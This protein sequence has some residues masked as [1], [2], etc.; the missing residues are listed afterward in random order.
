MESPAPH[1]TPSEQAPDAQSKETDELT[2]EPVAEAGTAETIEGNVAVKQDPNQNEDGKFPGGV[3]VLRNNETRKT[4]VGCTNS[5]ERRIRQHRGELVGGA[6][7]TKCST[8]WRYHVQVTG[9][10]TRNKALSF[11]W[12]V[13]HHRFPKAAFEG[14]HWPPTRRRRK[15]IQL[16]MD[17]FGDEKF[18][19]LEMHFLDPECEEPDSS[20]APRSSWKPWRKKKRKRRRKK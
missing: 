5:F 17:K 20:E 18:P 13:K 8:T 7:A 2:N 15:Q 9:F 19:D 10:A 4:Y 3:Y 6:K 16:L 1:D 14:E 11:E 12:H